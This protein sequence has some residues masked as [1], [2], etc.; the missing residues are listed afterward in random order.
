[1]AIG[2]AL[3]RPQT[4][5]VV[6]AGDGGFMMTIQELE[7]AVR[8]RV[9]L[10]AIVLNDSAY[11]P[12][13]Q[14]LEAHGK[15]VDLALFDEVDFAAVARA[16]GARGVTL[17]DVDDVPA[18][19]EEIASQQGPLVID[20]KVSEDEGHRFRRAYAEAAAR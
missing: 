3:A 7:T 15:P 20:V 2:A 17:R 13:V 18:I 19:A 4:P 6:C 12:E 9:P 1:M 16:F 8:E 11:A 14:H 10:L 5:C